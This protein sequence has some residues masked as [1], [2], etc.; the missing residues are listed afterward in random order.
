MGLDNLELMSD[1]LR[2]LCFLL[3]IDFRKSGNHP[4][5]ATFVRGKKKGRGAALSGT[6]Y[7]SARQRTI[8]AMA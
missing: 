7:R 1:F 6:N 3:F 2:V 8:V 5:V 4:D